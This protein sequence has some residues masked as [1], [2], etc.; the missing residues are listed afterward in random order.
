MAKIEAQGLAM[1]VEIKSNRNVRSNPGFYV[2]W[3]KLDIEFSSQSRQRA[4]TDWESIKV[5]TKKKRGMSLAEMVLQVKERSCPLKVVASYKRRNGTE[6]FGY[7]ASTDRDMPRSKVWAIS[8]MR[9]KIEELFRTCKQRLAFGKLSLK[10]KEAAHLA[11]ALP[12]F[13]YRW[14]AEKCPE[15]IK[16]DRYIASIATESARKGIFNL[17]ST[18]DPKPAKLLRNRLATNRA[19]RKPC[20][21][22]AGEFKMAG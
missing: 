8:R 6:A 1:V 3:S 2:E 15:T 7:Y 20:D 4:R 22:P 18:I 5:K 14:L 13:L 19:H 10:G 12:L 16:I 11:V 21:S 17:T 9:W